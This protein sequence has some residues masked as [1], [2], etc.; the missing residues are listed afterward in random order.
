MKMH[1][2]GHG[3][4]IW[5]AAAAAG[6][7]PE[8]V[9]DYSA[10]INP[11]GPPPGLMAFLAGRLEEIT[12]YPDPGCRRFLQ[13]VRE[14]YRPAHDPVAGNGAGELIC[15]LLRALAPGRVMLPAPTF[16]LYARAAL[17][18]GME[19]VYQPTRREDF[20]QPDIEAF[21]RCIKKAAPAVVMVCNPNNPTGAL[22]SREDLQRLAEAAEFAGALLVVDEAFLEF[23]PGHDELTMLGAGG[24]VAVLRSLTKIFA[25]PGLRL[26][27][28]TVPE[29]LAERIKGL[30]DP[31]SVNALAQ[32]AGE[33]VLADTAFV[34]RTVSEVAE[35]RA[36][37]GG[38]IA[39][40]GHFAVFPSAANFLFL[41]DRRGKGDWQQALL[42]DLVLIRDCACYEGLD[43][44]YYRVAVR[45]ATDNGRL[46]AALDR[47]AGGNE[48]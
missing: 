1:P 46:L 5:T 27:F 36:A 47:A 24:N 7:A 17:A 4:D 21:C 3:G 12:R 25:L 19:V 44:S 34:R 32:S 15:L 23:C 18:A 33:Y 35:L 31:W 20:F 38:G 16:T 42:R 40:A 8:E 39:K 6:A 37:L 41:Q 22:Y 29:P 30:R 48:G 45:S 13:A 43:R 9:L 11:L 28:L 2:Y 26:G 14:R 10:N